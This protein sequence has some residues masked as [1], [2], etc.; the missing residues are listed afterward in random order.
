M[1]EPGV[2]K[3]KDL[4]RQENIDGRQDI[5]RPGSRP[6]P[7]SAGSLATLSGRTIL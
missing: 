3:A 4:P 6:A 7:P 5:G 2:A 1:S